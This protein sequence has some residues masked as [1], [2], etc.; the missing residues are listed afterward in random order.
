MNK[1]LKTIRSASADIYTDAVVSDIWL[2][3]GLS[4]VTWSILRTYDS[5]AQPIGGYGL[6]YLIDDIA[7]IATFL[8]MDDGKINSV[9]IFDEEEFTKI[10]KTIATSIEQYLASV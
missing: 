5:V 6:T 1:F 7:R 3:L 4:P 2:R 10:F 9:L 8:N